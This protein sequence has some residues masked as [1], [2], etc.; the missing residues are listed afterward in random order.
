MRENELIQWLKQNQWTI[1]SV[2]SFTGGLF[3][4][5]LTDVPG[6][7]QV[8]KGTL[9][10]YSNEIK[11]RLL[12][13]PADTIAKHGAVSKEIASLM[14]LNGKKTLNVDICISFTGNAGPET[15]DHQPVGTCFIALATASSSK[16]F[17]LSLAGSRQ[18]IRQAAVEWAIGEILK[19]T[20]KSK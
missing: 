16:V 11:T 20:P 7:S 6:S 5:T 17:T 13:I 12:G 14:A 15:M 2:E 10:T 8:F 19:Q 9:V 3:A 1:G 18:G 4:K